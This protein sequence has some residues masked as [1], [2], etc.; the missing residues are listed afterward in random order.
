MQLWTEIVRYLLMGVSHLKY[1]LKDNQIIGRYYG[2]DVT[3]DSKQEIEDTIREA[4]MEDDVDVS[5][6]PLEELLEMAD[7]EIEEIPE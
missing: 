4:L 7:Y 1:R 2:V 3:F 5:L 6:I